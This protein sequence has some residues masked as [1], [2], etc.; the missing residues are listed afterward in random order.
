MPTEPDHARRVRTSSKST[1]QERIEVRVDTRAH[2]LL[3]MAAKRRHLSLS[4]Y[5]R[6]TVLRQAEDDLA[7]F[8]E[9]IPAEQWDRINAL[10]EASSRDLPELDT[11]MAQPRMF[12]SVD[13]D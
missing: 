5:I 1:K 8:V 2:R 10:L 4:D 12:R 7:E 6:S 13:E 3:L 9:R 11:L